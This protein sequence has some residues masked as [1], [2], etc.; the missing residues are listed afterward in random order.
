MAF[1]HRWYAPNNAV[2]VVAGDITVAR[3]KPLA[4]KYYGAIPVRP[5]PQRRRTEEPPAVSTR[6]IEMRD[7]A[8][9]L[10]SWSRLYLAPSYHAGETKNAYPLQVLAEIVGGGDTSRLYRALVVE[11]KLAATAWAEYDPQSVGPT[12]FS[13]GASPRSEIPLDQLQTALVG[14]IQ[15]LLATGVTDHEVEQAKQRMQASIA[16]ARDSYLAGGRVLGAALCTGESVDDVESWPRRIALVT[17]EQ[18]NAAA[19]QVLKDEGSVTG[20]LLPARPDEATTE[21]SAPSENAP[22]GLSGR[23]IR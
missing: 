15:G 1:Y 2:L 13:V 18:V 8:V 7:P 19:R 16:Y 20:L 12:S 5:V 17:T 6:T 3:L 9:H 22:A 10:P 21:S 14:Q 11:Q 23:E 4:E